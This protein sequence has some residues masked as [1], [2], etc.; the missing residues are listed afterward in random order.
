MFLVAN[1]CDLLEKSEI[2]YKDCEDFIKNEKDEGELH[3]LTNI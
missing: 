1:K 2:N 3:K